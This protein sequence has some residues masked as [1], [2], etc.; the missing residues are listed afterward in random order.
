L[1]YS[2]EPIFQWTPRPKAVVLWAPQRR[3]GLDT[4]IYLAKS[5]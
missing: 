1:I 3:G 4:A 5:E 2:C